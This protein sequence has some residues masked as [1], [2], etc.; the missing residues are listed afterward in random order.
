MVPIEI[1]HSSE[2][3]SKSCIQTSSIHNSCSQE[4]RQGKYAAQ[5]NG[6]KISAIT[7]EPVE[8]DDQYEDMIDERNNNNTRV[9]YVND[10]AD[11]YDTYM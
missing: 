2:S 1:L 6:S 5:P 11:V 7:L 10:G 3:I 9:A 4:N 8:G